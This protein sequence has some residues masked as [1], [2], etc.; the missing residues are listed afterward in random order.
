MTDMKKKTA[1]YKTSFGT[2]A[3]AAEPIPVYK[4]HQALKQRALKKA[5]QKMVEIF[6]Y[7]AFKK[8]ADKSPFSMAEWADLLCLSERTLQR[9]AKA[10]SEFSGLHMERILQLEKLVDFGNDFFKE[11][12]REWLL[13]TPFVL[14]RKTPFSLLGSYSGIKTVYDLIGRIQHGIIA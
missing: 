12:F 10:N 3:Q 7:K 8:I 9:Y 1:F 14:N 5:P 13:S 11:N 4:A 6:N 2:P